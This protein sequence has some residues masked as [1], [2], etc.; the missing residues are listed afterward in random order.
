MDLLVAMRV[1]V[2]VVERGSLSVAARDLSM[3]Q[4]A[5]SERISRLESYLGAKLLHRNT[6][7]TLPTDIGLVFYERSKQT[8]EAAAH[9]ESI[10]QQDTETLRGTL[11][12]AAPHGLGEMILPTMLMRFREMHP[13]L[14]ID[15]ILND[16]IADPVTEGVD[17]AVRLGDAP[18]KGSRAEQIG[19]VG[20]MLV[21]APEYL[22]SHGE[23][24]TPDDLKDHPFMRVAGIFNDNLLP[25]TRQDE[26]LRFPINTVWTVSTWRPLRA[27]LLAG[28][29]IGVLQ[30][31]SCT[32]ALAAGQLKRI[33]PEY[34]I[35][36][37]NLRLI[38][39]KANPIPERTLQLM[40]FL[41]SE[42]QFYREAGIE[43]KA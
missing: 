5:V 6:R 21:A 15:L 10:T 43:A 3:G 2:R 20:R 26:T 14:N 39:P 4:P 32:D 29:G 37:F 16:R 27:L 41:K 31:P 13:H 24:A 30:M 19:F 40:M 9:A 34:E 25:L 11:R 12:I 17:L 1:F 7:S 36:G 35:P 23:P 18:E 42:L 22:A 38:Y 28:A 8:L 33:L